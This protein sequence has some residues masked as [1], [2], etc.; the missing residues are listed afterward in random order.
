[1]PVMAKYGRP[2][3]KVRVKRQPRWPKRK[4]LP[5]RQVDLMKAR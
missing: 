3:M 5:T 1:M 4:R 2:N